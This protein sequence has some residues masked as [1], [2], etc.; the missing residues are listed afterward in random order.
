MIDQK[1]ITQWTGRSRSTTFP[2]SFY[3]QL[4]SQALD[5]EYLLVQDVASEG[6]ANY[7]GDS[8]LIHNLGLA[9]LQLRSWDQAL[10]II[11]DGIQC[12]PD[13]ARLQG[14]I[15]RLWKERWI[16]I[17]K[18]K[19][20]ASQR[21]RFLTKSARHYHKG[22]EFNGDYWFAINCAAVAA[23]ANQ[24]DKAR[25]F[26]SLAA[27][28]ARQESKEAGS[29]EP[30][31]WSLATQA[32][33]AAIQGKIG[34][35]RRLYK[36]ADAALSST[37]NIRGRWSTKRQATLIAECLDQECST[38]D[39]CFTFPSAIVFS[40]HLSNQGR[41]NA[42]LSKRLESEIS[43]EIRDYIEDVNAG[44]GFSS[45]AAGSDI[46]FLEAMIERGAEVEITLPWCVEDFRKTSVSKFGKAWEKR[47]D[48]VLSKARQVRILSENY[49]GADMVAF[50]FCN[51]VMIGLAMLYARSFDLDLKS[52]AV[53]D[54]KQRTIGGAG[55][56]A[57]SAPIARVS[58]VEE[59]NESDDL[60][61]KAVFF[62]DIVGYSKLRETEITN[63]LSTFVEEISR[64]ISLPGLCPEVVNTW[65]D[66]FYFVFDSAISAARTAQKMLEIIDEIDWEAL[67]FGVQFRIRIGMHAGPVLRAFDPVTRQLSYTG[68]HVTRAARIEPITKPGTAFVTEEFVAVAM[69]EGPG[70][71]EFDYRCLG[72][73]P[74]AKGYGQSRIYQLGRP[75]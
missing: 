58:P 22:L 60:V 59:T 40:G 52:Y 20:L 31:Y 57:T 39:D 42:K 61:V 48:A 11:E 62:A 64:I 34:T 8:D 46:L 68:A 73:I 18:T 37:L 45:A 21:R 28:K 41:S 35:A 23:F 30:S 67:G 33:A 50:D 72:T 36:R 43:Q 38:Y 29:T 17:R 65:G 70:A 15:G 74:L 19:G 44:I 16:E 10:A 5:S 14:L 47:F 27:R 63:Y 53:W 2:L 75:E 25:D 71:L 7:P 3:H 55:S 9:L 54:G 26:A 6:L 56:F 24:P 66:A 32:E 51:R 1:L 4:S 69:A 13:D 49:S 12:N